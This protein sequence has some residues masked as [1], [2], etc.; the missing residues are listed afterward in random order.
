MNPPATKSAR[1]PV[2]GCVR[3]SGCSTGGNS[4]TMR[5]AISS[6]ARRVT[7][8]RKSGARRGDARRGGS[9]ACCMTGDERVVGREQARPHRVAAALGDD[10]GVQHRVRGR[11]GDPGDVG[12]PAVGVGWAVGG[13]LDGR[14]E[15]GAAEHPR[16]RV[17][18]DGA[19]GRR[20]RE[21]LV[22]ARGPGRGRT[23]P[24]A[25]AA[26]RAADRAV[27]SSSAWRRSTPSTTAPMAPVV[28]VMVGV[29]VVAMLGLASRR[30]RP[31]PR[32]SRPRAREP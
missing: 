8:S 14:R 29:R 20:E 32:R 6:P 27:A 23:A 5:S 1:R 26:R 30:T 12:V 3:T 16:E 10:L 22:L 31:C 7:R 15:R 24:S 13:V 18:P 17:L 19:E 4:A 25:R 21:L 28:G 2:T 11:L 9:T